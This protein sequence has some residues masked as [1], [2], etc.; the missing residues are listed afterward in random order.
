MGS[1]IPTPCAPEYRGDLISPWTRTRMLRPAGPQIPKHQKTIRLQRI[2]F[3]LRQRD[4]GDMGISSHMVPRPETVI[5]GPKQAKNQ[6]SKIPSSPPAPPRK[7]A[8]GHRRRGNHGASCEEGSGWQRQVGDP[9]AEAPEEC[10][11]DAEVRRQHHLGATW[12]G[13]ETTTERTRC[14]M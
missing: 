14:N 13:E 12:E 4:A 8:S 5:G 1:G 2:W 7:E 6:I 3:I 9:A 10:P 11:E